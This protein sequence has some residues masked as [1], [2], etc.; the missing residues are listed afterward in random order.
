MQ[1]RNRD[2]EADHEKKP[3]FA[4]PWIALGALPEASACLRPS[5]ALLLYVLALWAVRAS[6][7]GGI[8]VELLN[9]WPVLGSFG[10]T[11]AVLCAVW[12]WLKD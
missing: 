7:F 10:I 2:L 3:R 5:V 4:G 11:I 9:Y 8:G 12:V 1:C 6:P